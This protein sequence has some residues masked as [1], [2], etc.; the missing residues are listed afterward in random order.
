MY[1]YC[2]TNVLLLLL[3]SGI[4]VYVSHSQSSVQPLFSKGKLKGLYWEWGG[5]GTIK[6]PLQCLSCL[7]IEK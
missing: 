7:A 2:I 1:Y 3:L 6:R 5:D 4:S